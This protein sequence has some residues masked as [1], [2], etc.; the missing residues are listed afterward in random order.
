M[1]HH[2]WSLPDRAG[3]RRCFSEDS[4]PNTWQRVVEFFLILKAERNINEQGGEYTANAEQAN[5]NRICS[6]VGWRSA[7][8]HLHSDGDWTIAGLI[9]SAC[10]SG[11]DFIVIT[12][13]N[14]ASHHAE[15]D[16]LSKGSRQS[17]VLRGEEITTYGGH[18]NAG[19]FPREWWIDFRSRPGDTSRISAIAAQAHRAGALI[20]INHPFGLCGGCA[21]SYARLLGRTSTQLKFGM[22][23]GMLPTSLR[24]KC[25]TRSCRVDDASPRLVPVTLI[26]RKQGNRTGGNTC[27]VQGVITRERLKAI[28]QGRV[29]LTSQPKHPI[30]TFEATNKRPSRVGIGEELRL[31]GPAAISFLIKVE[32]APSDATIS[33]ISNGQIVRSLTTGTDARPTGDRD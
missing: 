1:A 14:T 17:L 16:R 21:W 19:D 10:N 5:F 6:L 4:D 27:R 8:A 2:F 9:S 29:Y 13:H 23:T 7:H 12:D 20:S 32:A 15:I 30:V 26:H 25:G 11:L 33:L 3:R 18:T 28:R 22:A 31:T 24:S